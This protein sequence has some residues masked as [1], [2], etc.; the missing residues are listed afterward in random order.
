VEAIEILQHQIA[1]LSRARF[2]MWS[3]RLAGQAE[4]FDAA[5]DISASPAVY[6]IP[7]ESR[8]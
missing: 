3:A 8:S 2:G 1:L 5:T 6:V 7:K 4:L